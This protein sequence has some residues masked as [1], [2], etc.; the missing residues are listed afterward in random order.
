MFLLL[1]AE[2]IIKMV[3]MGEKDMRQQ[4]NVHDHQNDRDVVAAASAGTSVIVS[5]V[6]AIHITIF[7]L[8]DGAKI[9]QQVRC[10][11]FIG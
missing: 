1:L 2:C 7:F 9:A 4:K 11:K 6:C 3:M 8:F 5:L 10:P